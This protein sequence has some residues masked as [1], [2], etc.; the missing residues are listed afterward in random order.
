MHSAYDSKM[1][2]Y[3]VL[4]VRCFA[5]GRQLLHHSFHMQTAFNKVIIEIHIP[6]EKCV[7]T[8]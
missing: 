1:F 3:V 8:P 6:N 7:A 2:L 5:N 4:N